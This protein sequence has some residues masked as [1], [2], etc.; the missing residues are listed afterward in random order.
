MN[1]FISYFILR[2]H[3][4]ASREAVTRRNREAFSILEVILALAIL[5]GAI[6]VL[7]EVARMGLRNAKNAQD[8]TRAQLLCKSK[9]AEYTSGITVPQAIQGAAFDA[10]DQDGNSNIQWVYSVEMEQIDQDGLIAL[11]VTVSQSLPTAQHP[12]Y[13]S[14]MRWITDPGITSSTDSSQQNTTQQSSTSTTGTGTA[15][16][17]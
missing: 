3:A 14:L 13:F 1:H 15:N 4:A 9:M 16:A 6:T 12:V 17:Q 5:A 7:G 8:L 2:T 10:I 11:R